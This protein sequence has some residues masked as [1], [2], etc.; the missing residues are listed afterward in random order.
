MGSQNVVSDKLHCSSSMHAWVRATQTTTMSVA[1]SNNATAGAS[2]PVQD[3]APNAAVSQPACFRHETQLAVRPPMHLIKQCWA[4]Q[5]A[6]SPKHPAQPVLQPSPA[7]HEETQEDLPK[8]LVPHEVMS[9]CHAAWFVSAFHFEE[10]A[11]VHLPSAT[12][13][14]ATAGASKPVQDPAPNAAVSQPA[15]FRHETQLA[16]R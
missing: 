10:S 7:I 11:S 16:V 1:F 13:N 15:C 8:H 14:N 6:R 9:F 2:K 5:P 12:S 4:V 3:P